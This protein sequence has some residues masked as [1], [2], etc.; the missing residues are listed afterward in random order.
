VIQS[1]KD[2]K[3]KLKELLSKNKKPMKN[4]KFKSQQPF[5]MK[6]NGL[7]QSGSENG[8]KLYSCLTLRPA[9]LTLTTRQWLLETSLLKRTEAMP[10]IRLSTLM[11]IR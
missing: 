6:T 5:R 9:F 1:K 11:K 8:R 10:Q 2:R 7:H 3:L 4:R